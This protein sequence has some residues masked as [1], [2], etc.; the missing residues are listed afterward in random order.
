MRCYY[1]TE[2]IH[3]MIKLK[4]ANVIE[5]LLELSKGVKL[6]QSLQKIFWQYLQKLNI[7]IPGDPIISLLCYS[8]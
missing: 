7:Y 6:V 2:K 4:I 1:T 5:E 3:K 8:E